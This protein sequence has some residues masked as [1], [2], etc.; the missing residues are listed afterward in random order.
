MN[1][2][3]EPSTMPARLRAVINKYSLTRDGEPPNLMVRQELGRTA[4]SDHFQCHPCTGPHLRRDHPVQEW[5]D[6]PG[7]HDSRQEKAGI[8]QGAGQE[9][10][11]SQVCSRTCRSPGE[12]GFGCFGADSAPR[13]QERPLPQPAPDLQPQA[14]DRWGHQQQSTTSGERPVREKPANK[15]CMV[16]LKTSWFRPPG[17]SLLFDPNY[18]SHHVHYLLSFYV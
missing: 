13:A 4:R 9:M 14:Q 15:G 6:L 8:R 12:G 2:G 10:G 18:F 5:G 7:S 3:A 17:T 11:A 16:P 1:G